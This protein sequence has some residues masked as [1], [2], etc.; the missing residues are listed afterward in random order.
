MNRLP[1]VKEGRAFRKL[2]L[3]FYGV[4]LLIIVSLV[5]AAVFA[6]DGGTSAGFCIT[7]GG[8]TVYIYRF[9]EGG[10]IV[11]AEG[12]STEV[13]EE[14]ELV[15]V[16][17]RAGEAYN[18]VEIDPENRTARVIGANCSSHSDCTKMPPVGEEGFILCAPH[19]LCVGPLEED[20]FRPTL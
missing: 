7:R 10:E 13:R 14:G 1:S 15:F 3:L 18:T 8:E 20:L 12:V 16:T 4:I 6:R 5:L 17:V 9:G 11:P 19:A 2:D